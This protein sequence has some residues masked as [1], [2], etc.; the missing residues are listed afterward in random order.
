MKTPSQ[1]YN[2]KKKSIAKKTMALWKELVLEHNPYCEGKGSGC[3]GKSTVGH[4]FIFQ[5]ASNHLRFDVKNGIGLCYKCHY[6]LHNTGRGGI[7]YGN[8]V[9]GR[10][11]KW[12]NY[13]KENNQKTVSTTLKWHEEQHKKLKLIKVLHKR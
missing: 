13:I 5:S 6:A 3:L 11:N 1:K 9:W 12:A 2:A 7:V 8:I 10:D 4:H